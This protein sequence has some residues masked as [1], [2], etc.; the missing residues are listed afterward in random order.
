[1]VSLEEVQDDTEMLVLVSKL[2]ELNDGDVFKALGW[3]F[4]GLHTAPNSPFVGTEGADR[5]LALLK[6]LSHVTWN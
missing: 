5:M 2:L 6:G 3:V 1:M 4:R